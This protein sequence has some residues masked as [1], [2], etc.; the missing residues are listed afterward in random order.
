DGNDE[1]FGDNAL[2]VAINLDPSH[3]HEAAIDVP[4]W[5]FG[6]PDDGAV[7]VEELTSDAHFV[8]HGRQQQ[9]RL[10]PQQQPFAIWRLR[11][12]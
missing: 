8:W 12:G 10:D 2:L 11:P 5:R 1:R 3:A 4:L 9:I 7:H 6:L